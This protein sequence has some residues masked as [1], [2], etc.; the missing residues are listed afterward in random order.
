MARPSAD[1]Q[2]ECRLC[3]REA[4]ELDAGFWSP[5]N[6]TLDARGGRWVGALAAES[7][8]SAGPGDRHEPREQISQVA[9]PAETA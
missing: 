4:D 5:T 7:A 9:Q 6:S 2:I 3:R 8:P 1:S